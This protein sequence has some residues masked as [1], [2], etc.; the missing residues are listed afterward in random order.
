[1]TRSLAQLAIENTAVHEETF[2]STLLA[3]FFSFKFVCFWE[4]VWKFK[5]EKWSKL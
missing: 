2:A 5:L 1:M 4:P 3:F